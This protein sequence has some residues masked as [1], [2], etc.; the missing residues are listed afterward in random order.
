MRPILLAMVN[1]YSDDPKFALWPDPPGCSGWRMWK[2]VA[3]ACGMSM[4]EYVRL[5]DR[6]NLLTGKKWDV[7]RANRMGG[8]FL[9][10]LAAGSSVV[11][12]GRQT[13]TAL[14]LVHVEPGG[15]V[16]ARDSTLYFAPHPSG[17]SRYYNDELARW[18]IGRLMG[19][20]VLRDQQRCVT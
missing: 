16:Q 13:W 8:Q 5:F 12:F 7:L 18:N 19:N 17:R 3:D 11:V 6:R 14:N 10:S 15:A 1:P 4:G 2:M 9:C 20:L